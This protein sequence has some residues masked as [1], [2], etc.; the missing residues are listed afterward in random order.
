M[1]FLVRTRVG[2]FRLD[3][4]FTP[5]ALEELAKRGRL[6]EAVMPVEVAVAHLPAVRVSRE[7]ARR[8]SLGQ[9]VLM[10]KGEE[11]ALPPANEGE[12]RCSPSR[13]RPAAAKGEGPL[14]RVKA[15]DG[16]FYGLGRVEEAGGALY[17]Y[18]H[19]VLPPSG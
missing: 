12:Q 19:R 13:A 2:P 10:R 17:L 15:R 16:S 8:F 18:P 14:A 5:E 7:E 6:D 1:S 3:D 4:A 9:I 11:G